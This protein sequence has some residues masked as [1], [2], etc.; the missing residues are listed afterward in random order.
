MLLSG[1]VYVMLAMGMTFVMV[2][3]CI[4][5]SMGSIVGLSGGVC[6]LVLRHFQTPLWVGVVP[7]VVPGKICA[8]KNGLKVTK[9]G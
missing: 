3:G 2:G 9:M 7:G 4:D 1:S 5:L 6:L 8:A